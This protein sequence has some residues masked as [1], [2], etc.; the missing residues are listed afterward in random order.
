MSTPNTLM[1]LIRSAQNQLGY[2]RANRRR[3]TTPGKWTTARAVEARSA[4]RT[5][6]RFS[7]DDVAMSR[8]AGRW[9]VADARRADNPRLAARLDR[10]VVERGVS[11]SELESARWRGYEDGWQDSRHRMEDR[12]VQPGT[13]A[14][15][16]AVPAAAGL[17]LTASLYDNAAF[18]DEATPEQLEQ[19][20]VAWTDPVA[21][22][23][24]EGADPSPE[25]AALPADLFPYSIESQLE[26]VAANGGSAG[27]DAASP[28]MTPTIE[29]TPGPEMV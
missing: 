21:P 2:I 24:T 14:A 7:A 9:A 3:F 6:G 1:S 19:Q 15:L 13:S 17:A 8:L 29:P 27:P 25:V 26:H 23:A 11:R 22:V 5:H 28:A 12:Y 20:D 18:W 4:A 16:A 10:E